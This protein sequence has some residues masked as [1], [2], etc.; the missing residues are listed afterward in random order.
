MEM[1][2]TMDQINLKKL[3][4]KTIMENGMLK[5]LATNAKQQKLQMD[6][7]Q[8]GAIMRKRLRQ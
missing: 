7:M 2:I 8:I 3:E 6:M 4:Q 1:K 5:T